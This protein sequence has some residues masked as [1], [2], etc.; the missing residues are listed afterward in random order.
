M[1]TITLRLTKNALL[2]NK[3]VDD[4]FENINNQLEEVDANTTTIIEN[5][6]DLSLLDT[7]VKDTIV[8]SIN[9][10][11]GVAVEAA[12]V[13]WS[14]VTITGGNISGTNW[15]GNDIEFDKLIG[16]QAQSDI[17]DAISLAP[18]TEDHIFVADGTEWGTS[19]IHDVLNLGNMSLQDDSEVLVTN[20]IATDT[21]TANV[22]IGDGGLLSNI[23]SGSGSGMFNTSIS[24]VKGYAITTVTT[25]NALVLPSDVGFRYVI[26]SIQVIN[27]GSGNA[28]V[29][30]SILGD[31]YVDDITI[32]D[33]VPIP[34]NSGAE[35]L[36][37]PKVMQ[38][39]NYIRMSATENN[40]LHATIT[41]E[42]TNDENLFG[43]GIDI[44]S[45]DVYF[46]LLNA[47]EAAVIESVLISNDSSG[48]EDVMCSVVWANAS[49]VIQG[50][51]CYNIIVP[52]GATIELLDAP[53]YIPKGYKIR[54]SSGTANRAEAIVAG[55]YIV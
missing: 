20:L 4:N 39:G 51:Y 5:V 19:S 30:A 22:F 43:Q 55:K 31:G 40:T 16:V 13:D 8:A 2:T 52:T 48:D 32:S 6:G 46:D 18:P 45:S 9:E 10:V 26:H 24:N 23:A 47:T 12:N 38:P 1:A 34:V 28:N 21:V 49:N 25:G 15:L 17:L 42:V 14:N 11:R 3:E 54:V 50:Y 7:T 36:R 29:T 53:K 41:Y 35:I 37:R 27:I 44:I 33:D